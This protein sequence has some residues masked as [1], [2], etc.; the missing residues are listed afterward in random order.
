MAMGI[1]WLCP[2][3]IN[4]CN[5]GLHQSSADSYVH[6]SAMDKLYFFAS[7]IASAARHNNLQ[8]RG[9][10]RLCQFCWLNATAGICQLKIPGKKV[11]SMLK[12]LLGSPFLAICT[13]TLPPREHNVGTLVFFHDITATEHCWNASR[14][15]FCDACCQFAGWLIFIAHSWCIILWQ[16]YGLVLKFFAIQQLTLVEVFSAMITQPLTNVFLTN[17][18]F[19][20]QHRQ[21]MDL[22]FHF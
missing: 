7:C 16:L 1:L 5:N 6:A 18:C 10:S 19:T 2:S 13:L 4:S 12:L 3:M 9:I 21:L 11:F 20:M 17:C 14:F 8:C 15:L 22:L